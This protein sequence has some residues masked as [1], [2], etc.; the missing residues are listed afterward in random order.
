[1]I[2]LSGVESHDNNFMHSHDGIEGPRT[3]LLSFINKYFGHARGYTGEEQYVATIRLDEEAFEKVFF[4]EEGAVRNPL[5]YYKKTSDG[6]DSE[7]SWVLPYDHVPS[8]KN[9]WDRATVS[10]RDLLS[11]VRY[12]GGVDKSDRWLHFTIYQSRDNSDWIE[13]YS[14][15]EYTWWDRPLAHVREEYF[16]P[17]LGRDMARW[18]LD[19][20][21]YLAKNEDYFIR[22]K[23]RD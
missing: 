16:L 19:E 1:M 20:C 21:T 8:E 23:T 7:G 17:E 9:P 13:L 12:P 15:D 2:L 4:H 6:R 18:Y 10:G 22:N 3:W 11:G 5:A 14:H